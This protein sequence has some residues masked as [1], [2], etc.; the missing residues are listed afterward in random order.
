MVDK[1]MNENRT[2]LSSNLY[3]Q[4]NKVER[5]DTAECGICTCGIAF[6]EC[7]IE[8]ANVKKH[9]IKWFVFSWSPLIRREW[10]LWKK[11]QESNKR[12]KSDFLLHPKETLLV[13]FFILHQTHFKE[14]FQTLKK[15][16]SEK[17]IELWKYI[18]HLKQTHIISCFIM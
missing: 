16:L 13:L 11:T 7:R 14:N 12:V 9:L 17:F 18:S 3:K 8:V 4:G 6:P 10:F 1:W 2:W 15:N 5:K